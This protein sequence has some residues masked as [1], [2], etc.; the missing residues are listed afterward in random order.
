MSTLRRRRAPRAGVAGQIPAAHDPSRW[1][2]GIEAA[3]VGGIV[4]S[5]LLVSL[6]V[7]WQIAEGAAAGI[8]TQMQMRL[9]VSARDVSLRLT[10]A[11]DERL[12]DVQ[13]VRDLLQALPPPPGEMHQRIL[14]KIPA[15]HPQIHWL[16]ITDLDG[17]V[18]AATDRGQIGL[19]HPHIVAR[20]LIEIGPV[21][22]GDRHATDASARDAPVLQ[23]AHLDISLPLASPEGQRIGTLVTH[24]DMALVET[25]FAQSLG[26]PAAPGYAATLMR[27]DGTVIHDTAG[28]EGSLADLRLTLLSNGTQAVEL[29]WPGAG[30]RDRV[31]AASHPLRGSVIGRELDW[32][33]VVREPADAIHAAVMQARWRAAMLCVAGGTLLCLIALLLVRRVTRPL[34]TLVTALRRFG[35]REGQSGYRAALPRLP[36][37]RLVEIELLKQS[38]ESMTA[39]VQSQQDSLQ[40]TQL[41]VLQTLGRAGEFRDNETGDHV[42]RMSR[43][44]ARLARLAGLPDAVVADMRLASQLHDIGKIGIP[45]HILLKP[46]RLTE[47]EREVMSHH[48]QIGARILSGLDAP[49]LRL[50]RDIALTHHERW[51]GSGYPGGLAGEAIPIAGRIVAICDVFDALR[52]NRPYKRAWPLPQVLA[53][54]REQSGSHFDPHLVAL[55]LA[56]LDDFIGDD[57]PPT[58]APTE[59]PNEAPTAAPSERLTRA[60]SDASNAAPSMPK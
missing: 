40:Q 53:H 15:S 42:Q 7:G 22:I 51:D 32:T 47:E 9:A 52:S 58:E 1:R 28:Q 18:Q 55:F 29:A 60:P 41:Q 34:R 14:D 56:H 2:L 11:L 10:A 44:C 35:E 48:P 12:A 30:A 49:M 37:T 39:A 50:A 8:R 3:L 21:A 13:Q 5:T 57:G 45:D 27:R 43:L 33:V 54:L 16:G 26:P 31:Y 24:I 23:K 36:S 46:G 6:L 19:A 25:L 59:V 17:T 4:V 38:F 20:D